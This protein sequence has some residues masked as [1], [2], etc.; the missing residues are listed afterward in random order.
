MSVGGPS[1]LGTLLVQRIDA[2]LGTTLA[3][4]T[5]LAS[6]ARPDA[7]SQAAE[8]VRAEQLQNQVNRQPR[9]AVDRAQLQNEQQVRQ[10]I[11]RGK[12][13]AHKGLLGAAKEGPNTGTTP[14]APTT[15][16]NAARTI[17]AL[18]MNF[19]E[20]PAP[21]QGR[22]PLVPP[23]SEGGRQ[24]AQGQQTAA[25]TG[26]APAQQANT[27]TSAPA[28][29]AQQT[30]SSGPGTGTPAQGTAQTSTTAQ[31]LFAQRV[32]VQAFSQALSNALQ[33]SGLFY[34]SHLSN[35]AFGKASLPT[36]RQEPQA[37]LT[38]QAANAAGNTSG[39][40]AAGQNAAATATN[41]TQTAPTAANASARADAA[42]A[43][44]G[45]TA[46]SA[47]S[48]QP[49]AA[50][51]Q[52]QVSTALSG[53]HP[54]THLLVRQQLEVLANQTVAWRGEAWPNAPMDLEIQRREPGEA[55]A[56]N[57][58]HWATRLTLHLPNLGEV[59]VRIN[60]VGQQ[61]LMHMVAPDSANILSSNSDTLRASFNASGLALSQFVIDQNDP[62]RQHD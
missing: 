35:M 19:P 32:S 53:L 6:G 18:L 43:P 3:Q 46:N 62:E 54:E 7:V 51:P 16:G 49:A 33:T 30:T 57:Q 52:P 4:Q 55:A 45:T 61:V 44:A 50:T 25:S 9:E 11:E 31:A 2:A 10:Q 39:T 24:P 36:V 40:P 14:S 41:T 26:G 22:Q 56:D 12:L 34:E 13:E 17:L 60:L 28:A 8:A 37:Q 20:Q 42:G 21:V 59:Q 5:N 23:P 29:G 47:A 58:Q 27:G 38:Q 1:G 48:S 15:L